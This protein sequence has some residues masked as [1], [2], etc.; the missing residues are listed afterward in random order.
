MV[1]SQSLSTNIGNWN[2]SS[3]IYMQSVFGCR[4]RSN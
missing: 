4:T 3:A 2:T 1:T